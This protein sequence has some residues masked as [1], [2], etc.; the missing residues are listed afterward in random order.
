[1]EYLAVEWNH[2]L[3]DMPNKIYSELDGQRMEV[4]KVEVFRNGSMGYASAAASTGS[5]KLGIEAIP[6]IREI[7]TQAE[8][9][10][11]PSTRQE[12]ESMWTLAT[13]KGRVA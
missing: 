13:G 2:N 4:R 10:P 1:M 3:P 6:P 7:A 9:K 8:F 11:R 5:S 12:F